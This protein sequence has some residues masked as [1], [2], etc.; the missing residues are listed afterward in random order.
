VDAEHPGEQRGGQVGG[1]LKQR[2]GT[3]L[4]GVDAELAE[5]LGE[6]AGAD[7]AS[8]LSAGEQPRGGFLA[9]DGGMAV[10]GGDELQ[11]QDVERLREGDWLAAQ[12]DRDVT[13]AG[14]NVG[15]GKAACSASLPPGCSRDA[16]REAR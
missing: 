11:G 6:L 4:P 5:P 1:E 8:W 7:R 12:P 10:P 14:L 15:G 2:G 16:S 13:S 3:G 9:A